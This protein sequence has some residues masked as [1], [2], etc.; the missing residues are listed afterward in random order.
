MGKCY[1]FVVRHNIYDVR[2]IEQPD[3]KYLLQIDNKKLKIYDTPKD[4][5]WAVGTMD[6]GYELWDA[7]KG[8]PTPPTRFD[9]KNWKEC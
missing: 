8:E 5:A 1:K 2:M 9:D 6:T 3:G 7:L 4:V